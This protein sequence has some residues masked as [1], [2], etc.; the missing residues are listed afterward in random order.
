[1]SRRTFDLNLLKKNIDKIND[2]EKEQRI[3]LPETSRYG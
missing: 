3:T 1:M 2:K